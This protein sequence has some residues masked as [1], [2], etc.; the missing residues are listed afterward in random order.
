LLPALLLTA[1][2]GLAGGCSMPHVLGMGSYYAVT[3][4]GTGR[5][6]YTDDL[7]REPRGV[8]EFRDPVSGAS[9]SLRS[10]EVREIGADEFRAG[11]AREGGE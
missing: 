1:L 4:P 8:V 6:Y 11:L 7:E 5:V 2:A 10:A 9:I 3:D